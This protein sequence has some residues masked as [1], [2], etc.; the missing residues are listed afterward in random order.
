MVGAACSSRAVPTSHMAAMVK[1]DRNHPSVVIWSYCNEDGCG[2]TGGSA[3]R[4]AT[5]RYDD[6]RPTLGNSWNNG[7]TSGSSSLNPKFTDVAGFSHVS[8]QVFDNFHQKHP[9]RPM[10][11]SDCCSNFALMVNG[12]RA[13]LLNARV[14]GQ[15]DT[16]YTGLKR[17]YVRDSYIN[18][19]VDFICKA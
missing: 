7:G 6:S 15:H 4:N 8:A 1:R 19:S 5:Y 11:A 9:D 10:M 18:G 13:E 3:F 12:D 14:Y 16:F 2:P 17:V